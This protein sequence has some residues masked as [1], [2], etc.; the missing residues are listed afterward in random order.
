[1]E[2]LSEWINVAAVILALCVGYIIKH[3]VKNERV[4][5]F[6]PQIC[7]AVGIIVTLC[8]DIPAGT[9]SVYTVVIGAISGLAATGLYEAFKN[10]VEGLSG[11]KTETA[12]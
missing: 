5:D 4:N 8:V 7:A 10:F 2:I 9:V 11:K 1:M 6:I 12:E 3:A